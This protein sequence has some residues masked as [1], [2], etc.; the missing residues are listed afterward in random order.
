MKICTVIGIS[1]QTEGVGIDVNKF[2]H[3]ALAWPKIGEHFH[4]KLN[5]HAL[6]ALFKYPKLTQ[7]VTCHSQAQPDN[8]K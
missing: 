6:A 8:F 7:S 3:S 5:R 1:K 2:M 4:L